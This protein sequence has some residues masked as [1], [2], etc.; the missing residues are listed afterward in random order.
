MSAS[1]ASS[2]NEGAAGETHA[3]LNEMGDQ[4]L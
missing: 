4:L 2:L 1:R 3:E